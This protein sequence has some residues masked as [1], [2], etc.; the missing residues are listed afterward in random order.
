MELSQDNARSTKIFVVCCVI[1]FS[2]ITSGWMLSA[3]AME[4]HEC[5][6]S[7]T[8]RQMLQSNDW[9]VPYYNGQLRLQKTPLNYWLVAAVA[10]VTGK[11]DEYAARLPSLILA[12]LSTVAILY[13]VNTWLTFR[14]AVIAAL[15]WCSSLGFVRYGHSA[16]PEM[17]L[18]CFVTI[19]FLSFYSAIVTTNRKKQITYMLIFWVSFSLA[20]LA[21]GPAP[22]PL[23]VVPLFFYF[24]IFRQWKKLPAML[25]VLGTAIF[26]AIVLP[27]PTM[28]LN[29]LAQVSAQTDIMTLWQKESVARFLGKNDSG[30]KPF[31]YY[32]PVM[33]QYMV[34]WAAFVPMALAA[35]FYKVWADKRNLMIFL[36]LWFV[37][38]VAVMSLSGGKRMHYIFPAMPAMAILTGILLEDMIFSKTAYTQRFV[39][40][41]LLFHVGAVAAGAVALLIYAAHK[42]PE[43]M[44]NLI[45][46]VMLALVVVGIVAIL[47]ARGKNTHACAA[48]FI[49]YC[50]LLMVIFAV[51]VIPRAKERHTKQ[52]ALNV[53]AEIP[54]SDDPIAYADVSSRFVHYFGRTVPIVSDTSQLYR[55]YQ[56]GAWI[57][58]TGKFADELLGDSRFETAKQ[59][60]KAERSGDEIV[61]GVLFHKPVASLDQEA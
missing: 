27:W 59:W 8:A 9:V 14:V 33:F 61:N 54:A 11:V 29:R 39:R 58:A 51:F 35:P 55:M 17:S 4:G 60:P 16:R 22:L 24:F 19:A 47:F 6:V 12:V 30:G 1:L 32:V 3:K 40:N 10:K 34:P 57:I 26:L 56:D 18:T 13:F 52:F 42:K 45:L 41:L 20:M 37:G 23:I 43:L 49:G 5:F 44:E 28:L 21:K 15:I 46:P 50:I 31:F 48:I 25:P 7:V 38:D 2:F 53:A 36:W